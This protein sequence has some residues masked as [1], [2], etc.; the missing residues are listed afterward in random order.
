MLQ[1]LGYL[2]NPSYY[3]TITI[4]LL[5]ASTLVTPWHMMHTECKYTR[6]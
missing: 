5:D 1:A 6:H 3:K 2:Q 4:M